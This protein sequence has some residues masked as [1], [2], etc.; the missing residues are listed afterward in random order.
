MYLV[1]LA[2]I[3]II[4]LLS[5]IH[6]YTVFA[7]VLLLWFVCNLGLLPLPAEPWSSRQWFFNPFGWQIV[8]FTGFALRMGWLPIPPIDKRLIIL[9][10]IFLII[11]MPFSSWKVIQWIGSVSPETKALL[12]EIRGHIK[13]YY[14]K[15]EL[16]ILR[17]VHFMALAYLGYAL[18]GEGGKNL[19]LQGEGY[20][21]RLWQ[22]KLRFI[23]KVG[24]QSLAVFVF[25]MA[26]ARIIGFTLDQL[27]RNWITV[28]LAN[29]TGFIL[30]IC[31]AYISAYF[32]SAP[33]KRTK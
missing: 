9:C 33:W 20:I 11:C 15:T 21:A 17:Y 1:I 16:G 32:R 10:F 24:Q 28:N 8:F 22:I 4:M 18:A 23:T 14:F 26:L 31:V 27:G 29:I 13:P 25:S 5:R 2:M 30:L 19:L 3:P 12:Q 6:H 7:F